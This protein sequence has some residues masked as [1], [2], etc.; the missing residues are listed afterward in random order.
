MQAA[1][2]VG[3]SVRT[4]QRWLAK[5]RATGLPGLVRLARSD[6]GRRKV[7]DDA[8]GLIEGMALRKPQAVGGRHL[9]EGLRRGTGARIKSTVVWQCVL[10]RPSSGSSDGHAGARRAGGIPRPL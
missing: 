9:S 8:V 2:A 1:G 5:Y 3:M 4:A 10:N 6:T 7:A